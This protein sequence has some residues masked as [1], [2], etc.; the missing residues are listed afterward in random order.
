LIFRRDARPPLKVYGAQEMRATRW[1]HKPA[2][3]VAVI[4]L[5]GAVLVWGSQHGLFGV[6]PPPGITLTDL[7]SVAQL[8]SLFDAGQGSTRLVLIMSPT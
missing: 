1:G 8:Q 3:A 7:H 5:A 2:A 6:T 4:A